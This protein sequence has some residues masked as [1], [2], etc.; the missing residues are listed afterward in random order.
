M[1]YP[2]LWHAHIVMVEPDLRAL[3]IV[4]LQKALVIQ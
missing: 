4:T 2:S 1:A 3:P